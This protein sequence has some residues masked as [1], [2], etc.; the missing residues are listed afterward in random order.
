MSRFRVFAGLDPVLAFSEPL[1]VLR[2]TA[3]EPADRAWAAAA[4]YLDGGAW[5]AGYVAYDGALA[6]GVFETVRETVLPEAPLPAHSPLLATVPRAEYDAAIAA[7][8]DA[9]YE[10]DVYQVNYTV[11]FAFATRVEPLALYAH[12]ARRTGAAY[13]AFVEDGDLA[14]LSWSPE[15]FLAFDGARITTKPMKGTAP[16]DRVAELDNPKNRAE[17]LMIV[18]LLR[19]DLHR[20][21]DQVEVERLFEIERYPTFATMTSTIAG[22]RRDGVSL[23]DVFRAAFPC[24]SVTGA[25]KRSAMQ[26]IAANERRDRGIYCGSIGFLSPQRRGWWNVAIR[27]A[28]MSVASGAGRFDAGGG[29]VADSTPEQEW[30]EVRLKARFLDASGFAILETFAGDIDAVGLGAHVAR[31]GRSAEVFGIVFDAERSFDYACPERS[32]LARSRLAQDDTG[33]LVRVRLYSDGRVEVVEEVL[34]VLRE[35]VRVCLADARVCSDDPFLRHKTTWRP[36]HDAAAKEARERGC[37]DALLSNE[38]GEVTEGWR[39]N[40]FFESDGQ[41]WTPPLRSGLLPGILRSRL[42][43]EGRVRERAIS[44]AELREA[45]AVFVGNSARGLLKAHVLADDKAD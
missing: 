35:P 15:L 16:L 29:I 28:Q 39:T 11:P 42:V 27:T 25:P 22:R 3:G 45:D 9:I 14:L 17:H 10:G 34:E 4:R 30:H 12:Y 31:M 37:F 38:R 20:I 19:N 23:A 1:E 40:V 6:L 7:I 32:A 8:R 36:A 5:V 44:P 41:L 24:G 18:D 13:Q 43:S 26:F 2:T 21:C 33:L